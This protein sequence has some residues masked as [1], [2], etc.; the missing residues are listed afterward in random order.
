MQAGDTLTETFTGT[1]VAGRSYQLTVKLKGAAAGLYFGF[2]FGSGSGYGPR[3]LIQYVSTTSFGTLVMSWTPSVT[4]SGTTFSLGASDSVST[5]LYID[6][7]VLSTATP[8]L[9]DRRGFKRTHV[10]PIQNSLTT[11]L[12][13]QIGDVWLAAHR[14]T[15][16]KGTVKVTGDGA[17]RH[18]LTGHSIPPEQLLLMTGD[19]IRLS[20]RIDPD[21]GGQTRDGRIAEV[22]WRPDDD[23]ATVAIDSSRTSHEALLQRL[24][25]VVGSA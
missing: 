10:L 8:T 6:S 1:F 23:A 17:V 24:A 16:L 9:V 7:L 13:N 12:G 2:S 5:I 18:V 14:T 25:V 4:T 15:P 3:I 21:T 11:A 22:T 20:H 19:M